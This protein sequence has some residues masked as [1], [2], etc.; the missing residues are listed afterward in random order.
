M[1]S[2]VSG[3]W[4]GCNPAHDIILTGK[5]GQR[6]TLTGLRALLLFVSRFRMTVETRYTPHGVQRY[7]FIQGL[8]RV[9]VPKIKKWK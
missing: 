8:D 4:H 2:S 6:Y 3:K 9:E 7:Y 1:A 5:D